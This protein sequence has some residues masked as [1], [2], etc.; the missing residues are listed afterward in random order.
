MNTD[1]SGNSN[2]LLRSLYVLSDELTHQLETWWK[3]IPSSAKPNLTSHDSDLDLDEAALMLRYHA[4]GDIICR[5]FLYHLC[6]QS[7]ET[8]SLDDGLLNRAL[9]CLDHSREFIRIVPIILERFSPKTE[10]C[11]H[12]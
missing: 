9:R 1:S 6:T 8:S 2:H 4:C 5:P 12:S 11:L 3:V 7:Y 10:M